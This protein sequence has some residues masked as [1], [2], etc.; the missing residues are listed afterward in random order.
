MSISFG[1]IVSVALFIYLKF[2][3][4]TLG[5]MWVSV[6]QAIGMTAAEENGTINVTSDSHLES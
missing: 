3:I 5:E 4:T 2:L 6:S 1:L